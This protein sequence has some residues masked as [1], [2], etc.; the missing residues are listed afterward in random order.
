MNKKD[1]QII[2]HL[3]QDARMSLTKMSKKTGIPVSTIFQRLKQ[4]ENTIIKKHTALLNFQELGYHT[5]AMIKLK[6]DREDKEALA[7]HLKINPSVNTVYK[8]N[9]GYDFLVQGIFKQI[10]NL[11][12][13]TEKLEQ[14]YKI[15]DKKTFFIIDQIKKEEFMND[16]QIM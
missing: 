15:T 11:E 13:F 7:S 6:V 4:H 1:L 9:N 10:K 8:I 12:E 16:I 3:R 5:I 2:T 14:K